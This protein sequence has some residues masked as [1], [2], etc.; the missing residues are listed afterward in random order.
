MEQEQR[1]SVADRLQAMFSS[2]QIAELEAIE[3]AADEIDGHSPRGPSGPSEYTD[4]S[5]H[6][7]YLDAFE[8]V[9]DTRQGFAP[10]HAMFHD[11]R[12]DGYVKRTPGTFVRPG[13]DTELKTMATQY[14]MVLRG[15]WVQRY[16]WAIPTKEVVEL[17]AA[18]SPIVEIG[19]GTG[20][21]AFLI[22]QVGGDIICSDKEPPELTDQWYPVHWAD[23]TCLEDG[24]FA[25]RALFICWPRFDEMWSVDALEFYDG[26]T[27]IYIGEGRSGCTAPEPFFDRLD[28]EGWQQ[29]HDHDIPIWEGM[30]DRLTIYER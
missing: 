16:A 17:I 30:K 13:D 22:E 12:N 24:G 29:T 1:E 21:W 15:R 8:A 10:I 20:Y 3:E 18:H 6:N 25:D 26:D 5:F 27:V 19:A 7:P 9:Y 14:W 23:H 28:Q 2:E 11:D 4:Q